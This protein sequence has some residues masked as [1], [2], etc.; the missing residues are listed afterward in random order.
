MYSGELQDSEIREFQSIS[1][2]TVHILTYNITLASRKHSLY[3]IKLGAILQSS[4]EQI[5]WLDSDNIAV[6]DPEYLFDLPHYTHSTAMFWPDFWSTPRKNPI[7][8]ILDIPCR[9]EDYEQES[10]QILINKRLAWKAVNL[11]LYFTSDQTFLR[12]SLGDKDACRFS[13]KVL[14][15]PSYFIRKFVAQAGF[16][17]IKSIE[18]NKPTKIVKFCGHTM[19]Q[20][21]PFG[22][23]LF[24]HAN[25]IVEVSHSIEP[26]IGLLRDPFSI[27]PRLHT[28]VV[29]PLLYDGADLQS[30]RFIL[31]S[32]SAP[33]YTHAVLPGSKLL[34]KISVI[35]DD[36][37]KNILPWMYQR[38][39]HTEV[40]METNIRN[41]K[42]ILVDLG[43]SYFGGWK[44]DATAAAGKWF[45]EYYKRFNVKFDRII[46]FEFLPLNQQD[47]WEQ[48][49]SDVFPIYTLI[50]VGVTESGKFNP[51]LMLQTIA[52]PSD[53][54]IV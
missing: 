49:P 15:T 8:K 1:N 23:I 27:C 11:A 6:R 41:P 34:N 48:L 17:Y 25:L 9:A 35:S 12:V 36:N 18:K 54:I 5:L 24:L 3:A 42:I 16:D 32:V 39:A 50:N 19:I 29:S 22:E 10:G 13:W 21:D 33:F 31:L 28:S 44:N 2:V 40:E 38:L 53:H 43:S 37:N 30:K 52:Q 14:G 7:W 47:A 46:A 20:Y 45:Y 4:F 51:W 26:L